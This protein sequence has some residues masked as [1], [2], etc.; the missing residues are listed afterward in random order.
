MK[1][2]IF[3]LSIVSHGHKKFLLPLLEDLRRL[4]RTDFEVILTI[5][6]PEDL[7]LD[8][9]VL[10]FPVILIHNQIPKSFAVNHNAAFTKSVGDYFVI[11]NPDIRM[12]ADPFDALLAQVQRNPNTVCAPLITDKDGVPEDSARNF[13]TPF[14]LVRKFFG[15]VFKVSL[16][17]DFVPVDNGLSMPDWVA[18]MFI[19]V[20]RT[21]YQKLHGLDERYRMYYEDV[22]FCARVCL[23]GYKVAVNG[24]VKVVHEAQRE[25]HRNVRYLAW[26]LTSAL[27]FFTSKVFLTIQMRR[28][29]RQAGPL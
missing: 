22:D 11:L 5:N 2:R 27:R 21:I 4:G 9:S 8:W 17:R 14:F 7:E 16:T 6:M 26:H 24:Y 12:A 18:G 29:L 28:F 25:S 3:S 15:K 13:P 1:S 20:P 10:P 23:A 19:V